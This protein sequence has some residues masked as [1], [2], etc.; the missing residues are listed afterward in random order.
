[1]VVS[2]WVELARSLSTDDSPKFVNGMLA[3]ILEL[4]PSLI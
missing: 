3:R 4:K 1:V 2:E